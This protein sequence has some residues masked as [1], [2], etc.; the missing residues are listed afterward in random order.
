[1]T[2]ELKYSDQLTDIF[3]GEIVGF[4]GIHD[5]IQE[6]IKNGPE[7]GMSTGWHSVNKYFTVRK[8]EW[9]LFTGIPGAGKTEFLDS[10]MINLI[11]AHDWKFAVFS[12]E[13]LPFERHAVSLIEKHL[14]HGIGEEIEQATSISDKLGENIFF[15]NP[16]ESVFTLTRILKITKILQD[17]SGIDALIIDPWNEIEH[18]RNVKQSE[19]DY[20]S[21]SLTRVRRFARMNDIHI[22][23]IAHPTKLI[24]DKK[25][26]YPVPTPYD[27]SGSAHW[28]NKADNCLSIWWDYKRP[29]TAELHI[30]KIRFREVGR[31]GKV[32][33]N[34]DVENGI[35][36]EA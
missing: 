36:S 19:T 1:M 15:I 33:M 3:P 26:N 22:F 35:Y 34:Y 16:H 21:E 23:I 11:R 17:L 29:G 9:T 30:Q 25:G 24:K 6:A 31:I 7:K 5:K 4:P 20:I 12:A 32:M 8:R 10:L 2:E 18:E 28:R 14:G 27:V 13:N